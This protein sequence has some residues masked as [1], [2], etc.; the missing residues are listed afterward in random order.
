V[1]DRDSKFNSNFWKGL[2]KVFG[3][4]LNFITTYHPK[5]DGQTK[6]VNWVIEDMLRMYVMDKPS[7]WEDYFHLVEFS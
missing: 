6:M 2:F 7:K 4:S 3:T 1:S 5:I